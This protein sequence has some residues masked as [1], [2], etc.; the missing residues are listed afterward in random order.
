MY[1]I[2]LTIYKC[3]QCAEADFLLL[4]LDSTVKLP[5][6]K[7]AKTFSCTITQHLQIYKKK[8]K[9]NFKLLASHMQM[10]CNTE[11]NLRHSPG[12]PQDSELQREIRLN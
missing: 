2:N 8:K 3:S 10:S 11:H 1:P 7:F 4:I 9:K 5:L 6:H 12:H